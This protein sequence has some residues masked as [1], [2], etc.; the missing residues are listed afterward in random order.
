ME[1]PV[2][3]WQ[4][5]AAGVEFQ[6]VPPAV[7]ALLMLTPKRVEYRS[8]CVTFIHDKSGYSYIDPEG[9]VTREMPEG[10]KLLAFFDPK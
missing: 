1:R 4:R 6:H 8:N 9:T 7:L 10:T 3:R 2:E 5:L